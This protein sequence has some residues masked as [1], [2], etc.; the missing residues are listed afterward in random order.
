MWLYKK[1]YKDDWTSESTIQKEVFQVGYMETYYEGHEILQGFYPV[2]EYNTVGE[3]R[4]AVNFLNGGRQR[5]RR[6]TVDIGTTG[7]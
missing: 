4:D 1:E 5:L 7:P 2:E 6:G 3:A